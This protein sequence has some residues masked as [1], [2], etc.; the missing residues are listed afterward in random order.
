MRDDLREYL[1]LALW[2]KDGGPGWTVP[3][4]SDAEAFMAQRREGLYGGHV[5]TILAALDVT[6]DYPW[7]GFASFTFPK[8]AATKE[9]DD[10]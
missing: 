1:I 4:I 3:N 5:D 8:G 6:V 9:A 2:H 10:A 7:K